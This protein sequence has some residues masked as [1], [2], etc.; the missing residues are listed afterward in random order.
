[1]IQELKRYQVNIFG[2][3][4][5]VLSDESEKEVI[6]TAAFVDLLMQET[7]VKSSAD[8]K[9]VAVFVALKIAKKMLDLE[10]EKIKWNESEKS[11]IKLIDEQINFK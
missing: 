1:M 10:A 6:D 9:K 8:P 2:E 7:S 5:T 4:Y 3:S 11:L